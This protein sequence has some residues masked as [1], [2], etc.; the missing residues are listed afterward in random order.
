M[1]ELPEVETVRRGLEPVMAGA[2]LVHVEQRRANLR[3]DFPPDFVS[4]LEGRTIT[5]LDRRAKYLLVALDSGERLMIHLGMSGRMTIH[6]PDTH[7]ASEI[8]DFH[9]RQAYYA[10][11]DHVVFHLSNHHHVIYNDPRRF[12]FM[13]MI[14]KGELA[15]HPLLADLGP[16]PLGNSF[17]AGKLAEALSGSAAP[18]KSALLDQKKIAGLGN[19]YVCEALHRAGL[20][21]FRPAGTLDLLQCEQLAASIRTVL[22][23]AVAA[24]GSTLKDYAKAD[25]SLGYFQHAFRVY[26]QTGQNCPT[27]GCKGTIERQVQAGRSSFFCAACQN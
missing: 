17:D 18:L 20:S 3:F 11:H 12:G 5:A 2:R 13:L 22:Q 24:G 9:H 7:E 16:E 6:P 8:G 21:P 25:G 15:S 19:I 4:R 1:P 10:K 26:D 27:K 14:G 23:E